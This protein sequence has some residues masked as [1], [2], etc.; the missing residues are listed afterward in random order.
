MNRKKILLLNGPNLNMLGLRN[1]DIYGKGTLKD[2]ETSCKA[3]AK[4]NNVDLI[5]KQSNAEHEIIGWIQKADKV[6]CSIIINAGAYSHTSIA[7]ADALEIFKGKIY[8]V[9]ISNIFNR[10][11]YRKKSYVSELADGIICGAGVLGYKLAI[12]AIVSDIN[13]EK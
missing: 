4:R 9:H 5:A 7:I 8:E 12:D 11:E 2:L 3:Y 1:T 10:D 13:K 6:F